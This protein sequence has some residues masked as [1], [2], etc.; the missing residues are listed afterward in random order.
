MEDISK[1]IRNTHRISDASFDINQLAT[2]SLVL[3]LEDKNIRVCVVD[4]A[5]KKC[6][7]LEDYRLSGI[8]DKSQSVA[9]LNHIYDNHWALKAGYWKE[10]LLLARNGAYT[11]VPDVYFD[12]KAL[13][14]YMLF[15]YHKGDYNN[16]ENFLCTHTQTRSIFQIETDFLAWLQQTYPNKPV[17]IAHQANAFLRGVLQQHQQKEEIAISIENK[18]MDLVALKEGKVMLAN[19]Y[20]YQSPQDFTYFVLFAIDELKFSLGDCLV[21]LYGEISKDSGIY[22]LLYKYV[23]NVDFGKKPSEM[24]FSYVFDEILEHRYFDLY[25]AYLLL[26]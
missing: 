26:N 4:G 1:K 17:K 21:T 16:I 7:I 2:Y 22:N 15:H 24:T 13:E 6:L 25:N 8:S 9:C 5:S 20:Y 19:R 18:Y 23:Q 3:S 14:T 12:E 10:V 11:L